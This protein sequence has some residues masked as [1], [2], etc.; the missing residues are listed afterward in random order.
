[1]MAQEKS[2]GIPRTKIRYN[3]AEEEVVNILGEYGKL[4]VP[5]IAEVLNERFTLYVSHSTV[6]AIVN[7]ML[8][9]GV[10]KREKQNNKVLFE[11]TEVVS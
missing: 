6:W 3:T 2:N 11:L 8:G 1:M 10:L 9:K 5:E 4:R 7:R